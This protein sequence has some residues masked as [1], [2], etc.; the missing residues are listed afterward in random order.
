M[1]VKLPILSA[2]AAAALSVGVA[3]P[4]FAGPGVLIGLEPG[5]RVNVRSE[6]STRSYSPHYGLI[7]DRIEI[8]DQTQGYDGYTWYYVSFRSGARGWVRGDFVRPISYTPD[9]P[10]PPRESTVAA[11]N[12]NTYNVKVYRQRGRLYMD[13]YNKRA[14]YSVLN[15]APAAV[16]NY[17]RRTSYYNTRGEYVYKVTTAPNGRYTLAVLY[18]DRQITREP[19]YQIW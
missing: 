16:D 18:N 2:I 13:V 6:P 4:A 9:R 11:F 14:G 15:R 3:L 1:N 8:L 19:G 7:G 17:G 12:T 5:A 10:N